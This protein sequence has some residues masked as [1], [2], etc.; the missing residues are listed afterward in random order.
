MIGRTRPVRLFVAALPDGSTVD[1]LREACG[2]WPRPK[3]AGLRWTGPDQWHVTLRFL[4]SIDP[5]EAAAALDGL[6]WAAAEARL[7]PATA[8]LG[9]GVLMVPVGGLDGLA[10][11]VAAATVD[12][13][14]LRE[15]RPFTGHLTL[16]RSRGR[17]PAGWEGRPVVGA[18]PVAEVCLVGSE[19]LSEG[20]RYEVLG[21]WPLSG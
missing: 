16:A 13:G 9:R 10:G 6:G 11:A 15:D 7:G 3:V 5:G 18:F 4:G 1:R 20:A 17:V 12:L 21:R 19:T 2:G 8:L 14:G